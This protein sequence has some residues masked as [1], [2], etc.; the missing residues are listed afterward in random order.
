[1]QIKE[2]MKISTV[3]VN[4]SNC[5]G[6]VVSFEKNTFVIEHKT[7][8]GNERYLISKNEFRKKGYTFPKYDRKEDFNNH[9]IL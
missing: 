9:N 4:G 5:T 7:N 3:N 1:M 2:G 8:Y 6:K